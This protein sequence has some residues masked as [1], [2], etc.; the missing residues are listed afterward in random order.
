MLRLQRRP[1]L[2]N[3]VVRKVGGIVVEWFPPG[4]ADDGHR[5]GRQLAVRRRSLLHAGRL[6]HDFTDLLHVLVHRTDL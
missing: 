2:L 1:D 4:C 6:V 3:R 5:H